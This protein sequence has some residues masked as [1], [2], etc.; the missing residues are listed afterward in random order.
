MTVGQLIEKLMQ[1]DDKATV[2]VP[3]YDHSYNDIHTV[4]PTEADL[5]KSCGQKHMSEY[6]N[7][8]GA[9]LGKVIDVVVIN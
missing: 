4:S 5:S 2:V 3:G 7:E 6:Y 9:P 1:L 8:C